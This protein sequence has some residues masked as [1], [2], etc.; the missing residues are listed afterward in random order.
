MITCKDIAELLMEYL[1]GNLAKEYGDVICQHIRL[2]GHCN[3]LVESYQIT[4]RMTRE[5]PMVAIPPEL[6]ERLRAAMKECEQ[7]CSGDAAG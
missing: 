7:E 2:C 3:H 1:D 5:L 6:A 4:V